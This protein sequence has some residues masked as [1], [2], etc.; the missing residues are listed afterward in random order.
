[1]DQQWPSPRLP[2]SSIQP[3]E[4]DS[5]RYELGTP[6]IYEHHHHSTLHTHRR[7]SYCSPRAWGQKNTMQWSFRTIHKRA[8]E[9][10]EAEINVP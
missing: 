9:I 10:I 1:M 3:G 5:M 7:V 8:R 6:A 2:A 4:E